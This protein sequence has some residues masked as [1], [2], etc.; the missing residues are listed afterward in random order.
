MRIA[1]NE[2]ESVDDAPRLRLL[3]LGM[4]GSK[5]LDWMVQLAGEW[6]LGTSWWKR[7]W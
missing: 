2:M 5:I 1:R 3:R 6:Q 4:F 7:L